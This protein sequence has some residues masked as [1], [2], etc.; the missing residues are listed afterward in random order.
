M[1]TNKK[2][3]MSLVVLGVLIISGW[4]AKNNQEHVVH[5]ADQNLQELQ[6]KINELEEKYQRLEDIEQIKQVKAR[7][8]RFVDEKN[9]RTLQ[10][11]LQMMLRL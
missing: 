2:F 6:A 5:A 9:G 11:S 8:F 3:F 7:Y 4:S 10:P 1:L